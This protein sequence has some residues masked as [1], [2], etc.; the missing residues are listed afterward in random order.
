MNISDFAADY[1]I[2]KKEGMRQLTASLLNE[3][4]QLEALRQIQ[5]PP[6]PQKVPA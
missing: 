6:A 5:P 3:V 1:L 2:N 4:M